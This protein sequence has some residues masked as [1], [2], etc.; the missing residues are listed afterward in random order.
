MKKIAAL[1][2]LICLLPFAGGCSALRD[3]AHSNAPI[4]IIT[5]RDFSNTP[6]KRVSTFINESGEYFTVGQEKCTY[7]FE[8]FSELVGASKTEAID[9]VF[10][11]KMPDI[12]YEI[13]GSILSSDEVKTCK[14]KMQQL[15]SDMKNDNLVLPEYDENDFEA[16]QNITINIK[17]PDGVS[18]PNSDNTF[19]RSLYLSNPSN[20]EVAHPKN[21]FVGS[22]LV[23]E[24]AN[25]IN[26]L[27]LG[28]LELDET[29]K[30][31]FS[32]YRRFAVD[33]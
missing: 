24:A 3:K 13:E 27:V 19:V 29:E 23:D 9:Y 31:Y 4:I 28:H 8:E 21:T 18:I 12:E 15:S 20:G 5:C 14:A 30:N 10:G 32:D 11:R 17:M 7:T 33:Q 25:E 22:C 6:E 2:S 16:D 26:L 1:L